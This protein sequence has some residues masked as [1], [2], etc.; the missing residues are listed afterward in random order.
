MDFVRLKAL[1]ADK[2]ITLALG[3]E[4]LDALDIRLEQPAGNTGD[5]F[6]G[7]AFFLSHTSTGD[8]PARDRSFTAD[9]TYLAHD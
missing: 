7:T 5:L 2:Y 6:S 3:R 8:S 9:F 4:D 1:D